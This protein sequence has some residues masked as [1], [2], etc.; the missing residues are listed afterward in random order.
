MR[1]GDQL[2]RLFSYDMWANEQILLTIQENIPFEGDEECIHSFAHIVGA[3]ELWY[4]RITGATQDQLE[5]WPEHPLPVALQKLKTLSANWNR[6]IDSNQSELDR[7]ISYK[8]SSGTPFETM[9]SDILHHI[10][11][12]GQHHRAQIAKMLRNAKIDPPGTDFIFFSRA[13]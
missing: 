2:L 4:A 8:N 3:Q 7:P 10:I 12:H 1:A 11:I 9:L 13:N 6:L 5:V